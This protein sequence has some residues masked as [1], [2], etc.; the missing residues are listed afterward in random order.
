MN[1]LPLFSPIYGI[2][3]V[4]GRA[5]DV[6]APPYDVLDLPEARELV[7]GKPWSFLHV[8]RPEVDFPED[9]DIYS[10]K[11]Y[12]RGGEN[13]RRMLNKK[14]L[15]RE[16]KPCFYIYRLQS[17]EHV[18][19]GIAGGASIEGYNSGRIKK[20]EFT[21]PA[22]ETDRSRQIR[23]ARAQ[24]G[25]CLLA[26]KRVD[27]INSVIKEK[28]KEEPEYSVKDRD[29]VL[30][31]I[32]VLSNNEDI[33]TIINAFEKCNALYICDGHH[34]AAAAAGVCKFMMQRRRILHSEKEPYNQCLA[35]AYPA[36]ELKIIGYNRVVRDLNGMRPEVF[37]EKLLADFEVSAGGAVAP[38]AKGEFTMYLEGKWYKLKQRR[39]PGYG[40]PVLSLD[41]SVLS[42]L[43]FGKL[44]GI[45]DL[46][47]SG[48]RV[49]FVGGARGLEELEKR[50][51]CGEMRAAFVLYPVSMKEFLEVADA[52]RF[53]PPKSTWFEPKLVDGLISNPLM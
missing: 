24:T 47:I 45:E 9:V 4:K 40:D 52:A 21:H 30:H 37:I 26:Y 16:E 44:L 3:P 33:E 42:N 7:K 2:R 18:Q 12:A 53:M 31:T 38:A 19:T 49:D 15:F 5:E 20:H 25:P 50:V 6:I 29:G 27:G 8:S 11:V 1:K 46:R 41:V 32:W 35:V 28:M 10:E 36:D 23:S 17:G 22:K 48:G 51:N 34:R 14:I 43:I 39:A 13:F